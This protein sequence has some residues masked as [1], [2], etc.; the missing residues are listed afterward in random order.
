MED[1]GE[2]RRTVLEWIERDRSALVD[3]YSEFVRRP[4]P[5]PPGDTR[6]AADHVAAFLTKHEAPFS[7]VAPKADMPNIVGTFD[8]ASPGRHLALNGHI[9]V[10]PVTDPDGWRRSPFSGEVAD[11]RVH[12]R[13]AA[14]MKCGT[15]ASLVTQTN[16]D[17]TQTRLILKKIHHPEIS[18][19]TN[20]ERRVLQLMDGGCQL[21]LGAHCERDAAGNFH[22]F[23]ACE[24]GGTMRRAQLSSSTSFGMAEKL[25]GQLRVSG[26]KV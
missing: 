16:G 1:V 11:G 17:D 14:D 23:A 2:C 7:I 25:V 26:F 21:P 3:F 19:L 10:Y 22:A 8:G 18:A 5:N 15:S 4:S 6:A 9:D 20:V 12:G 13:G 24:I